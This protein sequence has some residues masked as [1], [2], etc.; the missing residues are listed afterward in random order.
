MKNIFPIQESL[1][2]KIILHQ[3][4]VIRVSNMLPD[5]LMGLI[6]QDA[7]GRI[8]FL[9]PSLKQS[10]HLFRK[11]DSYGTNAAI[12]RHLPHA[13]TIILELDTGTVKT[14]VA[15]YLALGEVMEF[16]NYGRQYFLARQAFE[17]VLIK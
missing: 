10:E 14:T 12:L 15:T 11:T 16:G 1:S 13:T 3:D 6:S 2:S 5:K 17:E 9:K 7:E 4:Q 8:T